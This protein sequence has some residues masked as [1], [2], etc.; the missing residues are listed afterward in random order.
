MRMLRL[1]DLKEYE[2]LKANRWQIREFEKTDVVGR[3]AA[4]EE[5]H[6]EGLDLILMPGAYLFRLFMHLRG[7]VDSH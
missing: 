6:N 4:M 2:S 7:G 5:P 3:E 1:N